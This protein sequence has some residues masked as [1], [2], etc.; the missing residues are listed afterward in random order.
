VD[1]GDFL[2]QTVTMIRSMGREVV[3][4]VQQLLAIARRSEAVMLGD[5]ASMNVLLAIAVQ[6]LLMNSAIDRARFASR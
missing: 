4:Q 5:V 1:N 2:A 3:G 6:H